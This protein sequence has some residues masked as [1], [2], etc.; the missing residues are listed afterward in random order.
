MVSHWKQNRRTWA[1]EE[2]EKR[3]IAYEKKV[4]R[5]QAYEEYLEGKELDASAAL[6]R[7]RPKNR[8]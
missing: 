8:R 3:R 6:H 4:A 2:A 7:G 1:L 5:E